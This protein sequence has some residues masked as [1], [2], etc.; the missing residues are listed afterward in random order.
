MSKEESYFKIVV[1]PSHPVQNPCLQFMANSN[2]VVSQLKEVLVKKIDENKVLSHPSIVVLF[3]DNTS[4]L[5][6]SEMSLLSV[7]NY[8]KDDREKLRLLYGIDDIA[9]KNIYQLAFTGRIDIW[10]KRV[11]NE[12]DKKERCCGYCFGKR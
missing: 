6:P 10:V 5:V 7:F 3:N 9:N 11:S 4:C 8:Y 1:T 2:I 12:G